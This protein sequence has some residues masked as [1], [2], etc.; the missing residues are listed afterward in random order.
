ML[1]SPVYDGGANSLIARSVR[2]VRSVRSRANVC[3]ASTSGDDARALGPNE[4]NRGFN[5]G[6]F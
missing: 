2:S 3:S 5:D 1:G 4:R 6:T